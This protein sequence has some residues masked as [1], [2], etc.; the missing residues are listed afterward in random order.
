MSD[1]ALQINF[2]ASWA[3]MIVG[4]KRPI[5]WS[6][7]RHALSW[8]FYLDCRIEETGSP[9]IIC[10]VCH[11]V[12]LHSSE[13]GTSSMGIHLL[14]IAHIATSNELSV[15]EVSELASTTVDDT[16]WAILKRQGTSGI[17]IVSSVKTLIF[18]S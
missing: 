13:H 4:S 2:D 10:I 12:L 18:N 15:S 9:G 1:L 14:A 16:A 3:F 7:S 5:A 17:T 6:S 8:R 11:Q